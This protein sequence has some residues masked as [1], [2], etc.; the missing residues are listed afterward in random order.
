VLCVDVALV[1]PVEAGGAKVVLAVL[2]AHCSG[3]GSTLRALDEN[4]A[5]AC[6]YSVQSLL[7]ESA[8][9]LVEGALEQSELELLLQNC[10]QVLA[11]LLVDPRTGGLE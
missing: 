9:D 11:P 2:A 1:N 6:A 7:E 5:S 10:L 8:F 4:E 3:G